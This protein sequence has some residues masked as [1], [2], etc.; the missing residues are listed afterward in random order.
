VVSRHPSPDQ[1]GVGDDEDN[2]DNMVRASVHPWHAFTGC[3]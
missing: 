2:G 1:E 3:I